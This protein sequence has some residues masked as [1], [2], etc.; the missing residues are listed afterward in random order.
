ML[1]DLQLPFSFLLFLRGDF[2]V[3]AFWV[4]FALGFVFVRTFSS[5]VN[6]SPLALVND[7][8]VWDVEAYFFFGDA[9]SFPTTLLVVVL[10]SILEAMCEI[11]LNSNV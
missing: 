9:E 7:L 11:K 3:Y 1:S 10:D 2:D 4:C 5:V 6:R 8:G